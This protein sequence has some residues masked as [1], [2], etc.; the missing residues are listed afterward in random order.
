MSCRSEYFNERFNAIFKGKQDDFIFTYEIRQYHFTN[1]INKRLFESYKKEFNFNGE[2]INDV[3]S[4]LINSLLLMR[5]FFE[6][7][8]DST[9]KVV[10]LSKYK[11]Y[12]KYIKQLK[13]STN[14]PELLINKLITK[15]LQKNKFSEI[16]IGELEIA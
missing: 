11:I 7:Y 13:N 16:S 4:D 2:I 9:E 12:E 1:R 6:V 5:I 10:S 15:M 8:R 14:N 3:F